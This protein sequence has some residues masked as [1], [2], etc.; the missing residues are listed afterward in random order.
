M[1]TNQNKPKTFRK[2]ECTD[3]LNIMKKITEIHCFH[4]FYSTILCL[5]F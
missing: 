2:Y 1:L 5:I 3:I 4:S